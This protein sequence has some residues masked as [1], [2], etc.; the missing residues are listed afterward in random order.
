MGTFCG[1][2]IGENI[3]NIFEKLE[4]VLEIEEQLQEE[5]FVLYLTRNGHSSLT[6]TTSSAQSFYHLC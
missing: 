2:R 1:F 5:M 3:K 4:L 6:P